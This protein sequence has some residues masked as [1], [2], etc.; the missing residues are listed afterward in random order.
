MQESYADF[1]AFRIIPA[2]LRKRYP[3]KLRKLGDK[4]G[5]SIS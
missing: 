3:V 5:W 2:Y 1:G 4:E